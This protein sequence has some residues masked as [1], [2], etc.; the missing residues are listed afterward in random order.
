M[1]IKLKHM[2][3]FSLIELAIVI[4]LLGILSS[5]AGPMIYYTVRASLAQYYIGDLDT[6][7]RIAISR[8]SREIRSAR[9]NE[10]AD[11]DI[12]SNAQI[13][14]VNVSGDTVTYSLSGTNLMRNSQPL[15]NNVSG[16]AF[17]YLDADGIVTVT[18]TSVRF[19][20]MTL[21]LTKETYSI[22]L[23]SAVSLRNIE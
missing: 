3:G 17:V 16:L 14:F 4:V 15:A 10:A 5:I 8:M 12:S 23:N 18:N 7:G 2:L 6:H 13:T 19:I 20:K 21:T 9:S 22:I 1:K 11:L